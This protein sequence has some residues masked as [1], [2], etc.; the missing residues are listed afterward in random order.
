MT[1]DKRKR[2]STVTY[3]MLSGIDA[4]RFESSYYDYHQ[5][6]FV[7]FNIFS[8]LPT[9]FYSHYFFF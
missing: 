6:A 4:A 2:S 3:V 1:K 7:C 9:V 8:E 5:C